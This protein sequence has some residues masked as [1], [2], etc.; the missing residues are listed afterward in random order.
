MK[1]RSE[2]DRLAIKIADIEARIIVDSFSAP[3]SRYG[4]RD[5]SVSPMPKDTEMCVRYLQL[6]GDLKRHPRRKNLVK[7]DL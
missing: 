4:W 3:A 7:W 5:I 6:R 2:T 1:K